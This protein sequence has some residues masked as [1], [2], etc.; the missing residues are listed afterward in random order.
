MQNANPKLVKNTKVISQMSYEEA[1]EMA[2]FGAKVIYPPAIRP[3]MEKK[4]PVLLLNTLA[5]EEKGTRIHIAAQEHT[6]KVLG[7]STLSDISMI[8]ISGIGLA[9]TKG[10]A[11]RVFQALELM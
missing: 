7:V 4:I 8:T 9:G 1:F 5:P 2:Y 10:S 11:R 6:D 3:A